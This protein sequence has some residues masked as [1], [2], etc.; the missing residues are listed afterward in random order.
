MKFKVR[1]SLDKIV[2]IF[3]VALKEIENKIVA[4]YALQ[5]ILFKRSTIQ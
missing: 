4:F 5:I 2:G 3:R 1:K